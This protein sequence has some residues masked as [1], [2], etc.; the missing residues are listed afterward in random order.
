M[1]G[2]ASTRH[3]LSDFTTFR[4]ERKRGRGGTPPLLGALLPLLYDLFQKYILPAYDNP[5]GLG[6]G[7]REKGRGVYGTRQQARVLQVGVYVK[8]MHVGSLGP[9]EGK[10][11]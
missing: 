6:I 3:G 5:H 11:E 1:I 9:K 7:K 8:C 4:R 2:L 10:G